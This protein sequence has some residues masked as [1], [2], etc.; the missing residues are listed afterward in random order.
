MTAVY[1]R[2]APDTSGRPAHWSDHA[3][4]RTAAD[5]EEFFP[6]GSG[7]VKATQQIE[8]AREFCFSCPV[9]MAC[10]LDALTNRW[11]WGVWGGLDETQRRRIIRRG[12]ATDLEKAA[13]AEWSAWASRRSNPLFEAYA[14]RTEQ[15]ADG[16]VRWTIKSTSITVRGRV[17]TAAQLAFEIGYGRRPEGHVRATCGRGHCVAP[18]HLA[19]NLIRWQRDHSAAA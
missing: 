2:R 13:K 17:F 15:E 18:E 7:G 1:I 11:D 10:A 9:R 12:P 3:L 8:D 6:M 16:H 5:P 14:K 19:D 4:C